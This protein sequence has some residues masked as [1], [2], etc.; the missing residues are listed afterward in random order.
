MLGIFPCIIPQ[1][2]AGS[3]KF[4]FA[5]MTSGF[6]AVTNDLLVKMLEDTLSLIRQG[7]IEMLRYPD[8][9]EQGYK[10]KFDKDVSHY[11][12]KIAAND[13]KGK[14]RGICHRITRMMV[15]I[16]ML[17]SVEEL[18]AELEKN[19]ELLKLL[20]REKSCRH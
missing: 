13:E 15:L 6:N 1:L 19:I 3:N 4:H 5:V 7:K 8:F 9:F 12:N 17:S 10:Y 20:Q 14:R 2:R 16:Y 18:T 11:L